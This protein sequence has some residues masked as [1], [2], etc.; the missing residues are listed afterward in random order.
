MTHMRKT[1][2]FAAPHWIVV[3]L[4]RR[5]ER[6]SRARCSLERSGHS[7]RGVIQLLSWTAG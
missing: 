1:R 7:L 2:S 6:L 5:A 3:G 4:L